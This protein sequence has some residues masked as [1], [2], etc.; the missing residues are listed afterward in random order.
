ICWVGPLRDGMNLVAKE[1]VTC[2]TDSQG[3]LLLSEF[4]GAA[5]EMGEA[6]L[7]NPFDEDR[8]ADA[9][10]RALS[11]DEQEQRDR[12]HA[13]HHR[14][15]RNDVFHWGDRF[16]RAL[17][18]A[19]SARGRFVDTQPKRVRGAEIRDAYVHSRRRLLILDYDGTL[20]PHMSSPQQ[21]APSTALIRLLD[22][23]ASAPSNTVAL[24]SGRQAKDLDRWFGP[25]QSIW[26]IAEHG[27]EM[28]APNGTG[29]EPLRSLLSTDWKS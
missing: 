15:L 18:E 4:A 21:A 24:T 13:L 12:M 11:L 9:V 6:L 14:V 10:K 8:T 26:L 5:A 29:W 1:Y 28:K 25:L 27:A 17:E 23:L 2:K 19:A 16:L 20:V 3:V 7:I 22:N